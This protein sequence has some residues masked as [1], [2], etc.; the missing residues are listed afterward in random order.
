MVRSTSSGAFL[1]DSRPPRQPFRARPG[2]L[3]QKECTVT[4]VNSRKGDNVEKLKA[5][6]LDRWRKTFAERLDAPPG[7]WHTFLRDGWSQHLGE[8]RDRYRLYLRSF[9]WKQRRQGALR[10]A[11]NRCELCPATSRLQV[12]HV[13][14]TRC[15]KEQVEDLRVLCKSCHDV[16]HAA[17]RE[18]FI[19]PNQAT[20]HRVKLRQEKKEQ[21]EKVMHGAAQSRIK[22]EE[23]R[24][25][26][27]RP[28]GVKLVNDKAPS[29]AVGGVSAGVCGE[30]RQPS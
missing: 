2:V 1:V 14:Y 24:R 7:G 28:G 8:W 12:H 18:R 25:I 19:Q 22:P 27:R 3:P 23:P 5:H 21:R 15:G 30:T 29:L 4:P 9:A 13:T 17:A 11:E 6:Q 16:V 10:R 26:R 20:A